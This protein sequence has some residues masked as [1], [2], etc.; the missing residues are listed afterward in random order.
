MKQI[1]SNLRQSQRSLGAITAVFLL[2]LAYPGRAQNVAINATGSSANASSML[3]VAATDKGLL[4]PRVALTA[5]N[6]AAPVTSPATSLLLYN[7]AAAG[8][9]PNNVVPGYYY[10]NGSRWISFMTNNIYTADGMLTGSR[11][12]DVNGTN[13]TFRD[14]TQTFGGSTSFSYNFGARLTL[15]TTTGRSD[16]ILSAGG[17]TITL[18]QDPGAA[19]QLLTSG[20]ST[21]FSI[22]SA[23]GSAIP[24]RLVSNGVIRMHV[25]A[26]GKIGIGTTNMLGTSNP[27][28]LLAVNGSILTTGATYPDYVFENYIDGSSP[29][30]KEYSFLSLRETETFIREHRHLPGIPGVG[31]LARNEKG[32]YIFNASELSL[33][34]LEKVEELYLHGIEQQKQL[35]AKNK[36]IEDLKAQTRE[37][38]ARLKRLE[39]TVSGLLR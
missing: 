17:S 39:E 19:S 34:L 37:T 9:A 11:T 25:A 29:L 4:I 38:E 3:D 7:T 36:E 28:V 26:D 22:G 15:G 8:T 31:E 5:T 23:L 20:T 1:F 13:L 32:D 30:K 33:Q 6:S 18:F 21:G 2:I 27:A 35:E 10:W 24:V 14:N 16:F 12:V